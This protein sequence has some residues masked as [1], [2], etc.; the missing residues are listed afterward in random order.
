MAKKDP[1]LELLRLQIAEKKA[2]AAARDARAE[3]KLAL[4]EAKLQLRI[5]TATNNAADIARKTAKLPAKRKLSV[6]D[7][8]DAYIAEQT[9]LYLLQHPEMAPMPVQPED[10]SVTPHG[11]ELDGA[12]IQA[13]NADAWARIEAARKAA[14]QREHEEWL[15]A[16]PRPA[17]DTNEDTPS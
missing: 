6:A 13:N 16:Q 9:R 5:L 4:E 15:A 7:Q 3:R 14:A 8:Q 10:K 12:G 1:E 2:A 11:V 17:T